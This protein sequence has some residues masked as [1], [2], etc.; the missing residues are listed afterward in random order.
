MLYKKPGYIAAIAAVLFVFVCHCFIPL[1]EDLDGVAVFQT[2]GSND[3]DFFA[4]IYTVN[5][6]ITLAGFTESH[7]AQMCQPLAALFFGD[8]NRVTSG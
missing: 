8:E 7:L 1:G 5:R 4:R 3:D 2:S 6:H